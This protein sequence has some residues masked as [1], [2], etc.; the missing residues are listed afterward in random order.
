[1]L[2][3][4]PDAAPYL[5]LARAR[6][7]AGEPGFLRDFR[8]RAAARFGETGFPTRRDEAWRFNDLRPLT[9]ETFALADPEIVTGASQLYALAGDT[10]RVVLVNGRISPELSRIGALPP[11]VWLG[12]LT[13]AL[14]TRPE[15]VEG[16]LDQGE[17]EGRLPFAALNAALFAD[18]FVLALE[19]GAVLDRT[20]EIVHWGQAPTPAAIHARNLIAAG[21]RSRATVLET[22]AGKGR[23][24]QNPVTILRLGEGATLRHYKLQDEPVAGLHVALNR[25]TLGERACYDSFV[26]MLGGRLARHEVIAAIEGSHATCSINGAYMARGQQETTIATLVEHAAPCSSTREV[27]KGVAEQRAHGVFQGKILVRREAQKTDAH[28]LN[29]NLLLSTRAAID[30]KPELEIFADDVKCSHG[31]TVG[32]LDE[33]ALF[34]L[35][36]RGIEESEA[37]RM[38]IEAFAVD[39]LD[40]VEDAAVRTFLDTHLHRW[41]RDESGL[42][43]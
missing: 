30:S 13:D 2:A 1:M 14:A 31:A 7:G 8:A 37:R 19:P 29:K 28:Q 16:E 23:T 18:G 33:R 32:D 35:R 12:S 27:V 10:I 36:S 38:L 17:A 34:Y 26:L 21:A 24:W 5:D 22:F 43:C 40:L 3:V 42:S 6:P 25:V 4:K 39:A 20:L 41:L 15:L 9:G 11:G